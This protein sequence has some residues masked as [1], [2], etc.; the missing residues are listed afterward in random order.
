[1]RSLRNKVVVIT[2]A[3]RGIGAAMAKLFA[4]EEACLVVCGR[5]K[6]RLAETAQSLGLGRRDLAVVSAD[7]TRRSGMKKIIDTA[8]RRFGAIDVF[9]NNAGVG[10]QK[11]LADLTD[12][13]Y[14]LIFNTNCRAVFH[15]LQLLIPRM[16]EQ[17]HGQ[18]IN[19]SSMAAKQGVPGMAAY[20]ASKAAMN[21]LSESVAG[22]VR[23]DNIKVCV[24]APASTD[25][26]FGSR[27][28][29]SD[30]TSRS[31][32]PKLTVDEVAEAA[33]FLARQNENA[34]MSLA[35]IRPLIVK[36]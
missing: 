16:Q 6:T 9:I 17:G 3:S 20:A 33:V 29:P 28:Q 36:A 14:D 21:I 8:W 10:L 27:L 24:L 11:P 22:E 34:W 35:E 1:M 31:T 12:S 5:D 18:I 30:G 25:T 2:G 4:I 19:V 13:E 15:S 7:I 26:G 32:R 23:N